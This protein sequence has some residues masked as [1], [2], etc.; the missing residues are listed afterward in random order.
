MGKTAILNDILS[1]SKGG[2]RGR[3]SENK[4]IVAGVVER[5]GSVVTQVVPNF[6]AK[7]LLPLIEE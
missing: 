6:Q 1:N 2:K 7:T 3:G 4:T 5:Q